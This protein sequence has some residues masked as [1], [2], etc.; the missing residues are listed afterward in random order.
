MIGGDPMKFGKTSAIVLVTVLLASALLAVSSDTAMGVSSEGYGT[1]DSMSVE[2]HVAETG[3]GIVDI[4][5]KEKPNVSTVQVKIGEN[6]AVNTPV[7]DIRVGMKTPLGN[8]SYAV[9]VTAAGNPVADCTLTVGTYYTVNV[10]AGTGGSA[11]ATPE[12]TLSGSTVV[13]TATPDQGYRLK[14]WSCSDIT[15]TNNSFT[16]PAKDITVNAVFEKIP[17]YSVTIT[18]DGNGTASASVSSAEEGT[19]VTLSAAPAQGYIFKAWESSDVTVTDNSFT[20]PAK[21]VTVKAVFE[22]S[23]VP[24]TGITIS[25]SEL[26]LKIGDEA[27]LTA[28]V[29]PLNANDRTVIWS[30]NDSTAVS[31]DNGVITAL[32]AGIV[33]ITATSNDGG[34]KAVC[35]VTVNPAD[36]TVPSTDGQVAKE[37]IDKAIESVEEYRE[38]G[39]EQDVT[40]SGNGDSVSVPADSVKTILDLGSKVTVKLSKGSVTVNSVTGL[41]TGDE[42]KVVVEPV[43][44]PSGFSLPADSVVVDVSMLLG[45]K[46]LTSFDSPITI[47]IPYAL[48]AGQYSSKLK[49][50]HLSDDGKATDMNATY[51]A[52]S[53]AMVFT[54]DHLSVYAVTTSVETSGDTSDDSLSSVLILGVILAIIVVIL[55][56]AIG[57]AYIKRE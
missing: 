8:D 51:D 30:S 26:T 15:V 33:K 4:T 21:N 45:E 32:K 43:E 27:T 12:K 14:E 40:I 23:L 9:L 6:D 3:E 53:G 7:S 42:L 57:G 10:T 29:F 56:C 17:T 36:C 25:D 34:F 44:V 18:T 50:Y 47:S 22:S 16:M 1:S 52:E 19:K 38:E 55:V 49:V 37:D 46:K 28:T 5:L 31:V 39:L 41:Q 24:A 48:S 11:S 13:L 20:M 54:T 35:T 2:Y